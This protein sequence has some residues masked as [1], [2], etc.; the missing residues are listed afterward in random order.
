[1]MLNHLLVALARVR[2]RPILRLLLSSAA[3]VGLVSCG[4]GGSSSTPAPVVPVQPTVSITA[5][6][7]AVVAGQAL[8]L[9]WGAQN[10]SAAGCDASGA[11]TGQVATSGTRAVTP[12]SPGSTTYTI[13]CGAVS[14]SVTVNVTAAPVLTDNRLPISVDTGPSAAP[15]AL[16]VPFVSVTVCRPGTAVCQTID[17]VML[18]TGSYGL[19]LLVPL[20][21]ALALPALAAPAGGAVGECAQFID[22][23][24]WGSVVQADVRLAGELAP[25]QSIQAM[26]TAPGGV[27]TIPATCTG[28][29]RNIGSVAALGANGILGVGMLRQDCGSACVNTAV[30]ATYYACAGAACTATRMPLAQ[31]VSN[32]VA[33]FAA[34][35]NGV[36]VTLPAVGANGVAALAGTLTFGIGTQAN[37]TIAG[38][39]RYVANA[40]GNFTTLYKGRSMTASFLDSGSNGLYFNDASLPGCSLNTGFYCPVAPLTLSATNSAYDGSATGVVTFT[41]TSV[42]GIGAA[43]SAVS[44]GGNNGSQNSSGANAFD[45]GLPFFFGRRV[46][47]GFEGNPGGAYWA[48]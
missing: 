9:T 27:A 38:E 45:W 8:T 23:F 11:W 1:M 25:A 40:S 44:V 48:Y 31:Q 33:A 19:R 28:I 15:G 30:A 17:H 46:F 18:D 12:A 42:D 3:C 22:G 4:G 14:N 10:S 24:A 47:V 5:A 32:P 37:N 16:N 2:T 41:L 7:A 35:N 39:T 43:I 21:A 13:T 26:G 6:P 36:L 29:G 20:D 34:D